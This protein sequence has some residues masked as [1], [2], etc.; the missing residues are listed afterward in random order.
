[1]FLVG[2]P[3]FSGK[4]LLAHLLN[5]GNVVCLDEPDLHDPAQRHRG[6]EFLRTLFPDAALPEPP[7]NALTYAEAVALLGECQSALRPRRLGMKTAG[8]IFLEYARV[9]RRL[10]QPT[11]VLVRDVRDALAETALPVWIAGEAALSAEYRLVWENRDLADLCLRYEDLVAD[12]GAVL[13]RIGDL[14][15]ERLTAPSTWD[16]GSVHST[17]FKLDRHELLRSG[18]ISTDRVGVW[19]SSGNAFARETHETARL[20]G[21]AP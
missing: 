11:I 14:L 21:Y 8:R 2:G 4:T 7:V 5:Q 1:M 6:I 15:G 19:A 17:M 9:Y 13:G 3:A 18:R 16:P 12:P 20:M 10:G